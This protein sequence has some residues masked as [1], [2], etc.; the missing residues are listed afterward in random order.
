MQANPMRWVVLTFVAAGAFAIALVWYVR[1]TTETE[2]AKAKAE[3]AAMVERMEK[4]GTPLLD[5]VSAVAAPFIA[6]VG[7]GRFAQAHALLAGPYRGGV[8][9][10]AFADACRASKILIGARGVTLIEVRRRTA[11]EASTLEARGVLDTPAG[12]V[13]V[14]FTFLKEEIGPRILVVALAGVPVLQGVKT[15][16]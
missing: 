15:E 2:L 14:T 6:H 3:T 8:P 12:G 9:V 11:G 16:K 4:R 7:A 5:D 13:P 10:D 1:H